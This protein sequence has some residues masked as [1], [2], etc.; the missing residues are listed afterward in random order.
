MKKQNL[1]FITFL[2]MLGMIISAQMAAAE[3]TVK[4]TGNGGYGPYQTGRGGEFS[5]LP[6]AELKS[7]LGTYDAKALYNGTAGTAFQ[8]FCLEENEYIYSNTE[9]SAT[10]SNAAINGGVGGATDGE[11][12]I[13]VGTAYLYF[14]FAKGTLPNYNYEG[15]ATNRKSSAGELQQAIWWLENEPSTVHLQ[16]LRPLKICRNSVNRHPGESRYPA[17]SKC[18][19]PRLSPG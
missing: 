6:N 17:I 16:A 13:S 11:D 12:P 8:T 15:T 14:Q 18:S 4:T 10:I 7:V 3:Y 9:H 5:L 1:T 19:G 2:A